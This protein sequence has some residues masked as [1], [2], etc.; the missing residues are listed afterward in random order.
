MSHAPAAGEPVPAA[1]VFPKRRAVFVTGL[2]ILVGL[3]PGMGLP[4]ALML[5]MADRL[6]INATGS[7]AMRAIGDTVWP[8]AIIVTVLLPL[9]L[10]PALGMVEK[11]RSAGVGLRLFTVICIVAVWG[12]VLSLIGLLLAVRQ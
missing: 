9:P 6:I 7:T 3:V 1:P 8:L 12:L 11:W 10:V 4:G 5:S 2:L